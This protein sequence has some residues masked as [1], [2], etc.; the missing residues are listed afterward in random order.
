[1]SP[2]TRR[3][4]DRR[5]VTAGTTLSWQELHVVIRFVE[6][7]KTIVEEIKVGPYDGSYV[8]FV[9]TLNTSNVKKSLLV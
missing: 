5:H 3:I 9:H 1:M 8:P 7:I 2:N 4:V 6:G